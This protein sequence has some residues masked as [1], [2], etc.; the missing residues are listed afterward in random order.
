[1]TSGPHQHKSHINYQLLLRHLQTR[2]APFHGILLVK[3]SIIT[4]KVYK[5]TI[6]LLV[7]QQD[8][9]LLSVYQRL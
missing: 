7:Y 8:T 2:R 6:C 9:N 3:H 5:R 4:R 1:M